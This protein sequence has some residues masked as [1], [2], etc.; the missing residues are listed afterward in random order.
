MKLR[1]HA[2][3]GEDTATAAA[4]LNNDILERIQREHDKAIAKKAGQ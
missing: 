2:Y 3:P 1:V 4:R